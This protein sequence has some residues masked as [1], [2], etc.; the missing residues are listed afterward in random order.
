MHFLSY[1]LDLHNPSKTRVVPESVSVGLEI[2]FRLTDE[3]LAKFGNERGI[4]VLR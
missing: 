2:D 3:L 4:S 1:F